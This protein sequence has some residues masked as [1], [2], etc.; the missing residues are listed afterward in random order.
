MSDMK[1]DIVTINS[2]V[3]YENRWMKVKEDGIRRRDGSA[4]IYGFVD[5]ADFAVIVPFDGERLHLVEQFRYPIGQRQWEFPQ[6][7][8]E[9]DPDANPEQLARGELEEETGLSAERVEQIGQLFPLYGTANQSYRIFLATG[10]SQGPSR[11][12]L[13]EQ[14]LVGASFSINQVETMIL[15]GELRD[16]ATVAA[17]SIAKLRG[18]IGQN[19]G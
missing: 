7:S 17:L 14:D 16:A 19:G 15:S 6:G 11:L 3:V 5:K 4:G 1:P 8:W 9:E 10:L 2:R 18:L 13:E 12:S